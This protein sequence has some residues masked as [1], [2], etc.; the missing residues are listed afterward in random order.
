MLGNRDR[1][2]RAPGPS[3]EAEALLQQHLSLSGDLG[4]NSISFCIHSTLIEHL[5]YGSHWR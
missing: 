1:L 5:L 2:E 3:W 4:H